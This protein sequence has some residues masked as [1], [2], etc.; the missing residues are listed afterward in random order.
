MYSMPN[1]EQVQEGTESTDESGNW[2]SP[3]DNADHSDDLD[4]SE[5]V[6]SPPRSERRSKQSQGPAGGCGK[7]APPSSQVQKCTRTSSPKT[8]EK[9]TKHLKTTPSK[10]RKALPKIKVDVPVASV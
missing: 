4:G 3:D 7:A 1:G 2:Q 10:P 5:E 6:D 9:A 8:T